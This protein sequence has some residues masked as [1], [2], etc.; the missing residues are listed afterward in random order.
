[1][2]PLVGRLSLVPGRPSEDP[3]LATWRAAGVAVL[4]TVATSLVPLVLFVLAGWLASGLLGGLADP[5]QLGV[6]VWLAAHGVPLGLT[7]GALTLH[8]LGLTLV[9]LALLWRGGRWAGRNA[10]PDSF[11]GAGRLTAM[12]AVGYGAATT[13]LALAGTGPAARP[14]C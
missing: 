6:D 2:H 13:L 5:F 1:M 8:P 14:T 10:A 7:T 12:V 3:P 9:V 11:A 4:W